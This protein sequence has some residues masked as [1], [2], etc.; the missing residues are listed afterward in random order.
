[1]TID[2]LDL[3]E[4]D[5]DSVL[6]LT[7]IDFTVRLSGDRIYSNAFED[8]ISLVVGAE[9]LVETVQLFGRDSHGEFAEFEGVVP[10]GLD[11]GM[12]R[13]LVHEKLGDPFQIY[14]PQNIPGLGLSR[15]AELHRRE[16]HLVH[17][18]FVAAESAIAL[19]SL[20]RAVV[21]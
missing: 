11:F 4:K 10:F 8:G 1:M 7:G 2:P 15:P 9:Q 12:S 14:E 18:E 17:V 16:A 21:E 13:A 19:L 6:G 3:L 5:I 20:S